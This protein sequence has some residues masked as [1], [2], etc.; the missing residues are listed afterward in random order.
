MLFVLFFLLVG[1]GGG[2]QI[3]VY[4]RR[5]FI[6]SYIVVQLLG[7]WI[8]IQGKEKMVI[9]LPRKNSLYSC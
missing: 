2:R 7:S 4:R 1:V 8:M 9:H 5:G 3:E 6:S